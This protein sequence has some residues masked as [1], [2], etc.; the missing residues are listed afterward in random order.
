MSFASVAQ[1]L[2]KSSEP[3]INYN[4]V[5][6]IGAAPFGC[7]KSISGFSYET[8]KRDLAVGGSR[9]QRTLP[10]KAG[11]AGSW[12]QVTLKWGTSSLST[13]NAWSKAVKVGS[14]FRREVF[15]LQM[16]RSWEPTRIFFLHGAWPVKWTADEFDGDSGTTP[17]TVTSVDLAFKS[18][19]MVV[20][21]ID[22]M[23]SAGI[24]LP[25]LSMS[26]MFPENWGA[27]NSEDLPDSGRESDQ[28][29]EAG[30]P[31]LTDT[32][33]S[34]SYVTEPTE[35]E[36]LQRAYNLGS[37]IADL[38]SSYEVL[39]E[40]HDLDALRAAQVDDLSP[41]QQS[42]LLEAGRLSASLEAAQLELRTELEEQ[43][44]I[45]KAELEELN[46]NPVVT[47]LRN[48]PIEDLTL[49]QLEV[50]VQYNVAEAKVENLTAD[51]KALP[52]AP[53]EDES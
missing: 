9:I 16:N 49:P 47:E 3:E 25:S 8:P 52:A 36:R 39:A 32:T 41:D 45:A 11:E 13:L 14:F 12:G 7:F 20:T 44:T 6:F 35:E 2:F 18:M 31:V 34:P 30:S 21:R 37:E 29:L 33:A 28:T 27:G 46:A 43:Q 50:L 10:F 23:R 51:L 1:E 53:T 22:L 17:W 24:S 15:I 40:A 26:G 4:F 48:S 42:A 5:V 19:H 38:E